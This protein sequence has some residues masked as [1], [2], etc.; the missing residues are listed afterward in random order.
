MNKELAYN[1][2]EILK[3]MLDAA[4]QMKE[5]FS[6][7]NIEMFNVLNMDVF[8]GIAAVHQLAKNEMAT[9]SK[10][11]LAD[12]CTCAIESIKDINLLAVTCPQKVVQKL[13]SELI[14]ILKTTSIQFY[15]WMLVHNHYED[16]IA[17]KEY[18]HDLKINSYIEE[19]E[20]TGV[21]KYDL[22]IALLAYNHLDYTKIC[23]ESIFRNLPKDISIEL[24]LVNHGSSDGTKEY[25]ESIAD[26]KVLNIA[27]NGALPGVRHGA[28]QGQYVLN[29][30][31]DTVITENAIQNI[32][33]YIRNHKECG[34]A[35]PATPNVSNLQ[36][37][38]VE[39]KD[40]DGLQEFA[41]RNNSYDERKHEQRVR[42][43]NPIDIMRGSIEIKVL[44]DM[45]IELYCTDNQW[46]CFP[47]DKISLWMRRHGYKQTLLKDSYCHHFGSITIRN[48]EKELNEMT[49]KYMNARIEFFKAFGIDPWGTGFCYDYNLFEKYKIPFI[50]NASILGINCGLGSNPLKIGE[51]LKEIGATG[52]TICNCVQEQRYFDDLKGVSDCV[53]CFT[54]LKD[55]VCLTGRSEY[56]F[57]IIEEGLRGCEQ[58]SLP[59]ALKCAGLSFCVLIFRDG[60]SWRIL[61]GQRTTK[62]DTK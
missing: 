62:I 30:S 25:F 14:P 43:C 16:E 18:L 34:W 26:A 5:Y 39:Y 12:A 20:N 51:R 28:Y 10:V 31:N 8:D 61:E 57:I 54:D 3:T 35:V 22:T 48:E 52:S 4:K 19:A 40:A 47:D 38:P 53:Y 17:F 9:D 33:D 42:L 36:S 13:E 58:S 60:S 50:D 55:V 44:E 2:L 37:I 45:Y 56:E 29:I 24:L 15:F 46:L 41:H 59:E 6:I 49:T 11:R 32:Y 7:G 1:V 27:I 21:Y 23:L